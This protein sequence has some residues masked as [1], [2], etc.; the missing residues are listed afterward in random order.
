LR[1]RQEKS[2]KDCRAH[3]H[4]GTGA[5]R[6]SS[7]KRRGAY[8][9]SELVTPTRR[10]DVFGRQRSSGPARHLTTDC[11]LYARHPIAG[12]PGTA[13]KLNRGCAFFPANPAKTPAGWRAE[14]PG[15]RLF[16]CHTSPT[17]PHHPTKSAKRNRAEANLQTRHPVP[18]N[19]G[20]Y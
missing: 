16:D 1:C 12:R 11:G 2:T 10:V 19:Q 15:R 7:D 17:Q 6:A 13:R 9:F 14:A 3:H 18:E 8:Q 4:T 20:R 5:L